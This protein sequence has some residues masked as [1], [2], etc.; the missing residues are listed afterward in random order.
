MVRPVIQ[1]LAHTAQSVRSLR[2]GFLRLR[3]TAAVSGRFRRQIQSPLRL[4]QRREYTLL[5]LRRRGHQLTAVRG[6]DVDALH[7]FRQS[8]RI[9]IGN[10]TVSGGG[11][12]KCV[13]HLPAA[14]QQ[15][16]R[17]IENS[18]DS[19]LGVL[20]GK[21][22]RNQIC[23]MHGI[24]DDHFQIVS[25]DGAFQRIHRGIRN[26]RGN[27][28]FLGIFVICNGRLAVPFRK[29]VEHF[30]RKIPVNHH[31][32]III[33]AVNAFLRLLFR[34]HNHPIDGRSLPQVGN[35]VFS[36]VDVISVPVRAALV[37]RRHG[38]G[39]ISRIAIRVPVG[40]N[41][42]PSIQTGQN[43]NGQHN[44]HCEKAFAQILHIGFENG[45]DIA[46]KFPPSRQCCCPKTC[47][48]HVFQKTKFLFYSII[49]TCKN[50]VH[51]LFIY[52]F[53]KHNLTF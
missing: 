35:H 14:H 53:C 10:Q 48:R 45:P 41:V 31:G 29:H 4:I 17:L 24:A 20:V 11:I 34:V 47:C 3:Q 18:A 40:V 8:F 22:H 38:N 7:N 51:S 9:G 49:Y 12:G 21:L 28:I 43:R 33:A 26:F 37:Q 42:Q 32:C 19:A 2:R 27:R 23:L 5:N 15:I 6:A 13:Q 25:A 39:D 30:I 46:H 50:P 44:D 16:P 52:N 1:L 36:L